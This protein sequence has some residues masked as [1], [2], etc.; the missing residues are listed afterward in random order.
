ML[1]MEKIP[2]LGHIGVASVTIVFLTLLF[3][4]LP[5]QLPA[6]EPFSPWV[7]LTAAGICLIALIRLRKSGRTILL[8]IPLFLLC[9]FGFL[10]ETSYGVES[11]TVQPIYSQTYHVEVYDIHNFLPVLEQIFN[12]DLQQADWNFLMSAQ[13]F[14]ADGAIFVGVI[15]FC[16]AAQWITRNEKPAD[17]SKR[18]FQLTSLA[19][20]LSTLLVVIWLISL[21]ADLKNS[22]LFGFSA[23]RMAVIAGLLTLG[24]GVP[25]IG[26][27]SGTHTKN[28]IQKISNR[29]SS[30][31]VR[32][33]TTAVLGIALISAI[34][35]QLW[36]PLV[37]HTGQIAVLE[38]VSPVI[39]WV[40]ANLTLFLIALAAWNGG[41]QRFFTRLV[42]GIKTFFA[43][44]PAYIYAIFSIAIVG[45]AQLM[46]QGLVSLAKYIHFQNPWGE[47]WDY[48]LE[49][50]F[51]MTGAFEL[52]TATLLLLFR[53]TLTQP[54][55]SSKTKRN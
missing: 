33:V 1:F 51:E 55:N 11:G 44:N 39:L 25:V 32:V 13:F 15:L 28:V 42:N 9:V 26:W 19:L 45:F 35:Y 10:E 17:I 29:L 48:W 8:F 23:T 47:E 50:T 49:E 38:R 7:Y 21:P 34:A 12:R 54:I 53:R 30:R 3:T 52:L 22:F 14:R 18:V 27:F 2:P 16:L 6:P 41:L 36:A 5:F 20:I 24:V 31:K 43:D 4:F 40:T 37:T 46:D